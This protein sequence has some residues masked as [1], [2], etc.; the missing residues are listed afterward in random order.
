ML[1]DADLLY[2][3]SEFRAGLLDGRPSAG[4]CVDMSYALQGYLRFATGLETRVMVSILEGIE[5]EA[6]AE[7]HAFLMLPDGRILDATADQFGSCYP[8]VYLGEPL[9]IHRNAE[10]MEI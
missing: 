7:G 4:W 5:T 9:D 2:Q 6:D 3:A 8:A 10:P 1:T